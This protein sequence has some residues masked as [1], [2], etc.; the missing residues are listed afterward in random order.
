MRIAEQIYETV[1]TMPDN[2]AG[3]ILDFV[4]ALKNKHADN[5]KKRRVNALTTLTKYQGRFKA[6]KLNREELYDR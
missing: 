1:K 4:E 3:E 5:A 6:E 2:E